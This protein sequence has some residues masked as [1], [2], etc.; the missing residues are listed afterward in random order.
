MAWTYTDGSARLSWRNTVEHAAP[1][2]QPSAIEG[3]FFNVSAA[4]HMGGDLVLD[5]FEMGARNRGVIVSAEGLFAHPLAVAAS[6]AWLLPGLPGVD[7]SFRW[8]FDL[9]NAEKQ[10]LTT[11]GTALGGGTFFKGGLR[12]DR[13]LLTLAGSVRF[14]DMSLEAGSTIVEHMTGELPFDV[15]LYFGQRPDATVVHRGGAVGGG[16]I[17]LV[18]SAEDIRARP[19][20]PVYYERLRPYRPHAGIRAARLQSGSYEMIDFALEGR[21]VD[22]MLLADWISMN[23]LGGDVIG[24]M[25]YQIGRDSTVRGDMTFKVS[26]IDASYFPALHLEPGEE[27]Q[28]N[29]DL[30]LAFLLGPQMRDVT[31]NMNVTR[32]GAKALDRFLQ[33]LD[34]TG[35]DP[36]MQQNRQNLRYVRLQRLAM[37][38]RYGNLNIDLEYDPLVGIPFTS[39]GYRP[40]DR[41]ML[42]R[43]AVGETLDLYVQP[44]VESL[45]PVLGWARDH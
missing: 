40:I 8:N 1:S 37:W 33:L 45:R 5:T 16:V 14:E 28:L 31:M 41:E 13:G 26:N 15:Q 42:R 25:A 11:S 30:R 29:S 24:N 10:V 32:I 4:Y 6:R 3:G 44:Y 27:S 20:R 22:G 18:T 17:S 35:Q 19:A 2:N 21:L 38:V 12:L 43:Y 36:K 39:I 7:A 34:P 23:V 9:R